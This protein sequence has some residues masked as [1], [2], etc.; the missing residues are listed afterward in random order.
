[1]TQNS[2]PGAERLPYRAE[3]WYWFVAGDETRVFASKRRA[4][5]APDDPGYLAHLAAGGRTSRIADL[6]ELAE[7]LLRYG[8]VLDEGAQYRDARRLRY[9]RELG[10]APAVKAC[11]EQTMGDV[12]DV[13]IAQVEAIRAAAGVERTAEF[14]ELLRRVAAI[15]DQLPKKGGA[16]VGGTGL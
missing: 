6:D 5:V 10:K 15:K 4:F 14:A 2:I 3:D 9:I 1:M 16:A 8:I 7:V 11:F 13:L 12:M